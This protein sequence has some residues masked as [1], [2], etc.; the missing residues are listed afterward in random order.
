M[1]TTKYLL[2]ATLAVSGMTFCT[3]LR[4]DDTSNTPAPNNTVTDQTADNA[5]S[6]ADNNMEGVKD[7]HYINNVREQIR[8]VTN[9]ALTKNDLEA[10]RNRL[11][12][13]DQKRLGD[14]KSDDSDD[15]NAVIKDID[16]KWKDKYNHSFDIDTKVALAE[17]F[18]R[19]DSINKAQVASD[20]DS[21]KTED[22]E[23]ANV[24][25]GEDKDNKLPELNLTF[26]R[27][28]MSWK[29]QLP[30][31]VDG[32]TLKQNL[33]A[34]LQAVNNDSAN[35]PADESQAYRCVSHHILM[36]ITG[37]TGNNAQPA[38]SNGM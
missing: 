4:A 19:I 21:G 37:N 9:A 20:T 27:E 3:T 29:L 36:G 26:V 11:T 15:L 6:T 16:Q 33:L 14:I 5:N 22:R 2:A 34:Q 31:A 7:T 12:V 35:W 28:H 30:A 32:P 10:I 17:P 38:A 1:K 25:V 24:T 13:A 18:V 8:E 23:L